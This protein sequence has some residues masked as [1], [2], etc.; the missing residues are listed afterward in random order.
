MLDRISIIAAVSAEALRGLRL[1]GIRSSN[2]G[3]TEGSTRQQRTTDLTRR[4][5]T[6]VALC[7]SF[8]CGPERTALGGVWSEG[9]SPLGPTK[10]GFCWKTRRVPRNGL[11]VNGMQRQQQ[12][13]SRTENLT[14][15]PDPE[16]LCKTTSYSSQ[17][18]V[19]VVVIAID[20]FHQQVYRTVE[21]AV[22]F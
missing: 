5:S 13:W 4:R 20:A 19:R 16:R 1:V 22:S 3:L 9:H 7:A 15:D 14:G 17:T 21:A 8:Q 6:H 18:G 11:N 2:C 12:E 10:R